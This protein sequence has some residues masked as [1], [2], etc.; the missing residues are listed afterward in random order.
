MAFDPVTEPP[1]KLAEARELMS[2]SKE[3]FGVSALGETR[4][5]DL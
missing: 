1:K 3:E 2:I 5:Y 4:T